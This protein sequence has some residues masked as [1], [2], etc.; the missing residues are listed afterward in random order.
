M[1][2]M[3]HQPALGIGELLVVEREEISFWNVSPERVS[4]EI[5]IHNHG[6]VISEPTVAEISAAPLGAFVKWRP[7]VSLPVPSLLPGETHVLRTEAIQRH[8]RPLGDANRIP[9]HKILT[10]LAQDD[11]RPENVRSRGWFANPKP[12]V[13]GQTLQLLPFDINEFFTHANVHWAGNLNVFVGRQSVE[14]HHAKAVRI[15]PGK[16]NIAYFVVGCGPD[17]YSFQIAGMGADWEVGLFSPQSELSKREAPPISEGD[18][19]VVRGPEMMMLKMCPPRNCAAGTLEVHVCQRSTQREA[20]V[21]F[22]LDPSAAGP[23]C[24]VVT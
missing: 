22:S 21:E 10:A 6:D 16:L 13:G 1:T 19:V 20:V 11:E 17:A 12:L 18:W 7:L 24:Y 4:I 8:P 9:P 2:A 23:G 5:P 3:L 15:Y 14:R